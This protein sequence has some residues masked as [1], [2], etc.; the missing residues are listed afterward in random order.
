MNVIQVA[1]TQIRVSILIDELDA[2][3]AVQLL[4]DEFELA[5]VKVGA[6]A[7]DHAGYKKKDSQE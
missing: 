5:N 3:A 2:P 7:R 4:H 6:K 1:T